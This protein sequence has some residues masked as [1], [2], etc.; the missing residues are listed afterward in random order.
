MDKAHQKSHVHEDLWGFF[1]YIEDVCN[2][3]AK[4]KNHYFHLFY[5]ILFKQSCLVNAFIQMAQNQYIV[6]GTAL[7]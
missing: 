3:I 7:F 6:K 1:L 4:K 5:F 2:S